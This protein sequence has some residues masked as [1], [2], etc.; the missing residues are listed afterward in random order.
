MRNQ[1]GYI[2]ILTVIIV[3]AVVLMISSSVTLLSIGEGQSSLA[4][5]Q[6]ESSLN[7]V[8]GCMEDALE[9]I[10]LNSAYSGG[11]IT[12]PEGVCSISISKSGTSYDVIATNVDT[13]DYG[14]T[15][16]VRCTKQNSLQLISWKE[17]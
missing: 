11:T 7:F 15:I 10:A 4:L 17:I 5:T 8:E 2:A 16:E 9:K 1:S 12:H 14:R 13:S 3:L 6:G